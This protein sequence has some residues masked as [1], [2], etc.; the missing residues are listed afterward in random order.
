MRMVCGA[1]LRHDRIMATV[2]TVT[3]TVS[4]RLDALP[5]TDFE[6]SLWDRGFAETAPVL[7]QKECGS[8]VALY[9]DERR[10]RSRIDMARHRFGVGEYK[11]FADPLPDLVQQLRTRL[12]PPLARIANAWG[13]ALGEARTEPYPDTLDAFRARC[14][15]AGQTRPTPLVLRYEAGGYNCLHQDVYGDVAFPLQAV[16]MLS[17]AETDYTG[18][19]FLLVEQRPRAQSIGEALRPPQGAIVLF[20]T[21]TR[22]VRGT[23]GFYRANV[24][25]GVSRLRSGTRY[26]LG[27]IFHDAR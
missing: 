5:W 11:Y 13:E 3:P 4:Q 10:F 26:A 8:I 6:R 21:R 7:T 23:R 1:S 25:H 18:G 17:D 19:E 16:V 2:M 22:P 14:A 9:D 27:I 15:A 12:Y 24:R 20:T